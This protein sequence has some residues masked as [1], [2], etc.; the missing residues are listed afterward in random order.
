MTMPT[1]SARR[2]KRDRRWINEF[3]QDTMPPVVD[4]GK[5]TPELWRTLNMDLATGWGSVG[6]PHCRENAIE[7]FCIFYG[8]PRS[9][10]EAEIATHYHPGPGTV[11]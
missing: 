9:R 10:V 7:T 11:N 1:N 5:L 8:I 3:P 4:K 2:T 6:L